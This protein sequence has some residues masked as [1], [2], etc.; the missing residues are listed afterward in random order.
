MTYRRKILDAHRSQ[1]RVKKRDGYKAT[2][3]RCLKKTPYGSF[4][5]AERVMNKSSEER[6][7]ELRVYQCPDCGYWH[8]TSKKLWR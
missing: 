8:L 4:R 7:K 3:S 6:G 5:E 1:E 2:Y